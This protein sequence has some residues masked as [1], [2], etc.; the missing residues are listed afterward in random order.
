MTSTAYRSEK[1]SRPR[2][3][4]HGMTLIEMMVAMAIS[5]VLLLGSFNIYTQ[6]R[7]SYR[8]TESV[9]H[10]QEN[11]RFAADTLANDIQLAQFWGRNNLT[12]G[13]RIEGV[14]IFCDSVDVTDWALNI[15]ADRADQAMVKGIEGR[16]DDYNLVCPGIDPRANS[17][18]LVIRHA[19]AEPVAAPVDGN[20]Q[21]QSK[22]VGGVI[23]ASDTVPEGDADDSDSS[24][25]D[26]I[27]NAYYVSNHSKYD[28]SLP[29]LRRRSLVGNVMQDQEIIP[30]VEN[31]Q[32]QFGI[33]TPD[34]GEV[35]GYVDSDHPMMNQPGVQIRSVRLWLLVRSE[36][37][38]QGQGY[39]DTK[40]YAT[41]DADL[42]D[43][44]PATDANYPAEFRR[45]TI[46]KT[47]YLRN[48]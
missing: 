34:D 9:A 26:V 47:I 38:E 10:L 32:V 8:T 4:Q 44:N 35:N 21:I 11:V 6:T 18:V 24:I 46:T 45:R 23:F 29:A 33:D 12:G 27:V 19:S 14:Q 39:R 20:V 42:A 25:H 16:D 22:S 31:M 17:D 7:A 40:T 15:D 2:R 13:F 36:M 3:V 37:T 1:R 41:P 28:A 43:I 5:S 30:G 48:M